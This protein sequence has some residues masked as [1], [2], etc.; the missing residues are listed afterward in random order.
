MSVPFER[1]EITY[2]WSGGRNV[3]WRLTHEP[4]GVFVEGSTKLA[5]DRFTKE[6]LRIAE[7]QLKAR[8][9]EE[10]A[11]RVAKYLGAGHAEE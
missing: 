2:Y 11:R 6:R 10:L 3:T 7:E 1:G 5:E 4:T 8:L 9:L